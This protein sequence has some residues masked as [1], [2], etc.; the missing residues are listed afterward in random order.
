MAQLGTMVPKRLT[1]AEL[2]SDF[3]ATLAAI[4]SSARRQLFGW[5][6]DSYGTLKVRVYVP[7]GEAL[8][9]GGMT[10]K[11]ADF[12][13]ESGTDK[14]RYKKAQI[15]HRSPMVEGSDR[16]EDNLLVTIEGPADYDFQAVT[17]TV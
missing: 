11:V 8:P 2:L 9:K 7:Q 1:T 6:A 15:V 4:P 14:S 5:D 13:V 10:L 3:V 17:L 12:Q 16:E